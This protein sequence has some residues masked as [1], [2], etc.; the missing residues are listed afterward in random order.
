MR[1]GR[2]WTDEQLTEAV[3]ASFSIA[4]VLRRLGLCIFGSSYQTIKHHICRLKLSTVHFTGQGHLRGKTHNW[5]PARPLEEMLVL[6]SYVPNTVRLK[7][8][9][10]KA[11]LLKHCCS[12]CG[13][14]PVWEGAPLVLILDHINGNRADNQLDNLR[15]L[16][17][18]CNSQQPTFAGRN[19]RKSDSRRARRARAR[20]AQGFLNFSSPSDPSI[21][22]SAG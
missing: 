16:C 13:R 3:Q 10:I 20:E 6:G 7:G 19:R 4:Q 17:P 8:R 15:L 22:P 12:I 9:L 14:P 11:G 5:S 1:G 2:K 21:L 18:N